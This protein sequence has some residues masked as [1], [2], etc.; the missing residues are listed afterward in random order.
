MVYQ[1][2][3]STIEELAR[4]WFTTGTAKTDFSKDRL[5]GNITGSHEIY[6][7]NQYKDL[8]EIMF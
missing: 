4:S 7:T 2:Q 5:L 8:F 6:D 3:T 1:D